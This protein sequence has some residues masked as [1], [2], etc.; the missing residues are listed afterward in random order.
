MYFTSHKI[1]AICHRIP[2]PNGGVPTIL[3]NNSATTSLLPNPIPSTAEVI[4]VLEC[5]G[6]RL[7]R[8]T[9]FGRDPP[10]NN[11]NLQN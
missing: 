3:A 6:A 10:R 7:T 8:E 1:Q 11:H 2:G 9:A 5:D 4:C